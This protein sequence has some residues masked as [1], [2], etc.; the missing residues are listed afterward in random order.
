MDDRHL[1]L[2]LRVAWKV[3]RLDAI[4]GVVEETIAELRA[5]DPRDVLG[6]GLTLSEEPP[7]AGPVR[8]ALEAC[9][10]ELR[11]GCGLAAS[12]PSSDWTPPAGALAGA[13]VHSYS[14]ALQ[15]YRETAGVALQTS[16]D[17]LAPA[18]APAPAAAH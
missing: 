17:R 4:R 6:R 9:C 18:P 16:L 5:L 11:C 14:N 1:D 2:I 8:A 7:A 15:R 13:W 3:Y 12:S 10:D